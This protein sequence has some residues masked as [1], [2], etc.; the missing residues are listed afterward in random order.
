[1]KKT[2][3]TI[4]MCLSFAGMAFAQLGQSSPD[5]AFGVKAGANLSYLPQNGVYNN[6]NKMGYQFGVWG[7][8]GG[9]VFQFQ[10]EVYLTDKN[11]KITDNTFTH[12]T[13]S[14]S[15]T[16]ID[17]PLL[18]VAKGELF[19]VAGRIYTGPLFSF[20]LTRKQV[21]P[22]TTTTFTDNDFV[23][24]DYKNI[25]YAWVFGV[26]A[27]FNRVGVDLRYEGGL[28]RIAYSNYQYS[29]TRM[30]LFEVSISYQIL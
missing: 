29:H 18:A 3:L 2:L 15:F 17:V 7:R 11:V 4:T 20:D 12:T 8:V 16:S 9:D 23:K 26:G 24:L 14:A 1:M 25:N 19:D 21:Y 10:P 5:I 6:T 22:S 27:D 28:N 30:S 13:N